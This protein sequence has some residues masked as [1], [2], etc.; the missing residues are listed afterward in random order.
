MLEEKLCQIGLTEFEAKVYLELLKVG[1]QATSTIAKLTK[2]NR[3]TAYSVLK[4]LEKKGLV[5][6]YC[7]KNICVYVPNDPNCLIG[8]VDRKCKIYDYYREELIHHIP[9]FRS[10]IEQYDF[11]KP[12]I[13]YFDGIEGVKHVIA[14]DSGKDFMAYL[15]IENWLKFG[16]EDLLKECEKIPVKVIV[17]DSKNTRKFLEQALFSSSNILF[18]PHEDLPEVFENDILIYENKVSIIHLNR[19][20]EYAVVIESHE[21]AN[22]QHTIF[23]MVWK[24]FYR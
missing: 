7:N 1:P 24:A 3:T 13:R 12:I 15:A 2:L 16:L 10:L 9:K 17:P 18:L 4:G 11:K 21:L 19:G 14:D 23:E 8:Y 6:S 20:M 5:S 22:M